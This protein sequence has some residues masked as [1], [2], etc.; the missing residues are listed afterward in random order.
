MQQLRALLEQE[1]HYL[2][3]AEI[4]H[5]E[6]V[7]AQKSALVTRMTQLAGQRHGALAAAGFA[8][9]DEGMEGWLA[10]GAEADAAGLWSEILAMTRE[11]K[12]FNRLNG[13]LINKHMA[14]TQGALNSLRPPQQSGHIYGPSGQTTSGGSNRRYVIG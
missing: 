4:E 2:M 11:A 5:L 9:R 1:Q 12:E 10:G 14:Y 7:A 8:A 3:K 13:M 6:E